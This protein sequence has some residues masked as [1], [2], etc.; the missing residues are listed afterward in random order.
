MMV[1][2]I[3]PSGLRVLRFMLNLPLSLENAI[4][5]LESVVP[6]AVLFEKL[7]AQT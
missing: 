4:G 2:A 7:H 1:H 3:Q 5:R 6:E